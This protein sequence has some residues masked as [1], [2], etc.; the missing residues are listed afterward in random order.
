MNIHS[1]MDGDLG[2]DLCPEAGIANRHHSLL[3]VPVHMHVQHEA[4][5]GRS[6]VVGQAVVKHAAQD[7]I[8][9]KLGGDL[10]DGEILTIKTHFGK[11][12]E[13][14]PAGEDGHSGRKIC[15]GIFVKARNTKNSQNELC[16]IFQTY[17][18]MSHMYSSTAKTQ[19]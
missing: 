10:I 14:V 13:L 12:V 8:H 15:L 16:L 1:L 6:E 11:Q 2:G 7:Q 3:R 19:V 5:E 18:W 9:R 4:A 17:F